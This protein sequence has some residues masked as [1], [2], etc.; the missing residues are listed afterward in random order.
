MAIEGKYW[1]SWSD[2]LD[3]FGD[4]SSKHELWSALTEKGRGEISFSKP[5]DSLVGNK[6]AG[7]IFHLDL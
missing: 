7:R 2:E 4:K 1:G 3:G 6:R 5:R